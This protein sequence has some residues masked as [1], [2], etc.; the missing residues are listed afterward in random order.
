MSN[1]RSLL[2]ESVALTDRGL[3]RNHNEDTVFENAELGLAVLADGMGGYNAGEV[4]SRLAVDIVVQGF[5]EAIKTS[6]DNFRNG[7]LNVQNGLMDVTLYLREQ[8]VNANRIVYESA[9]N[10]PECEGMGTTIV[11][12]AL[13]VQRIA[14]A[15]VGDSR[16]YRWR[17]KQLLQLTRDHS[18]L[19]EQIDN[20]EWKEEYADEFPRK[21]LVTRALGVERFIQVDIAEFEIMPGD[22]FLMCSDGLT[23][24]LAT[25]H[26]ANTLEHMARDPLTEIATHLVKG[27]N[28]K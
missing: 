24:M 21:N 6:G 12:A 13:S 26:I 18:L 10:E 4:A 7:T 16:A 28:Q 22:V 20:D 1:V 2:L 8:I 3:V 17:G 14:I 27:A 9:L 15:H 25:K 11:A 5:K 23:D 19:Q